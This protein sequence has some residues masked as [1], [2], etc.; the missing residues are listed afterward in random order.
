MNDHNQ[1]AAREWLAAIDEVIEYYP[2]PIGIERLTSARDGIAALL[3][4][5]DAMI[6]RAL[7]AYWNTEL[8]DYRD[9][10]P[11]LMRAALL[12]ALNPPAPPR[13]TQERSE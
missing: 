7:R 4:V 11:Q 10:Q 13:P 12:A 5:D 1:Q 2:E 3:T 6:F 9:A 8:R